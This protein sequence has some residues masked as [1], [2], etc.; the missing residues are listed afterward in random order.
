MKIHVKNYSNTHAITFDTKARALKLTFHHAM[1]ELPKG[2][3]PVQIITHSNSPL[4]EEVIKRMNGQGETKQEVF[5]DP[6]QSK[7]VKLPARRV[8]SVIVEPHW[9][10]PSSG[11]ITI[12]TFSSFEYRL[13]LLAPYKGQELTAERILKICEYAP[14]TALSSTRIQTG[15]YIKLIEAKPGPD[16]DV[17]IY[18]ERAQRWLVMFTNTETRDVCERMKGENRDNK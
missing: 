8:G 17:D 18:S 4:T 2:Q 16:G 1:G 15:G 9:G 12:E 3:L 14:L 5:L 13:D 7:I 6:D 11:E 10:Y